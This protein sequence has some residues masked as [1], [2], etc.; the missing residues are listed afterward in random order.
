MSKLIVF[1]DEKPTQERKLDSERLMI[2]RLPEC[3][4]CLP[5]AT[6]SGHHAQVITI[7]DNSFLED[8][9]STNGTRVNNRRVDKYLLQD[10][11]EIRIG[12]F[13]LKFVHSVRHTSPD[14]VDDTI[15]ARLQKVEID[16]DATIQRVYD[17]TQRLTPE[18]LAKTLVATDTRE[19]TP[20]VLAILTGPA[21]GKEI[22]LSR[23][24]T[25][26]GKP[27]VQMAEITRSLQGYQFCPVEGDS[28]PLLNG[29]QVMGEPAV[30][31]D[32]DE[33]V[34]AGI[35]MRFVQR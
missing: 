20:A 9:S 14:A 29:E 6:V 15:P 1:Q 11:D 17:A 4:L 23:M 18:E 3:D 21:S 35:Q 30:L 16:P 10:G 12:K 28:N 22:R 34:L 31:K 32:G 25:T 7:R 27:G 33:I 24:I 8:L 2:G 5:H 13:T 19:A 26:L